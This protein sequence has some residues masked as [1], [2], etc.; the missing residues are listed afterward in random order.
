MT[1]KEPRYLTPDEAVAYARRVAAWYAR[2][3]GVDPEDCASRVLVIV[4][5]LW[6][7]VPAIEWGL[8]V[9]SI[10]NAIASIHREKRAQK[11]Q[12]PARRIEVDADD[13]DDRS[14]GASCMRSVEMRIDIDTCL[15][16]ES[17]DVRRL[18]SLLET[19][20]VSEASRV[21]GVPRTTLVGWLASLRERM[22]A[23]GLD[24]R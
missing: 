22:E 12:L 15:A 18:C 6:A 5:E 11:R 4:S 17:A 19:M 23:R 24:G 8:A 10:R 9:R 13:I 7:I 16:R 14:A 21:M 3:A 20:S 2:T 1:D